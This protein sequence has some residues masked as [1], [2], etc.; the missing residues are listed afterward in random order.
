MAPPP[1]ALERPDPIEGHGDL[2]RERLALLLLLGC[3]PVD[4]DDDGDPDGE[5]AQEE[6][7]P[8]TAQSERLRQRIPSPRIRRDS[9]R[10]RT[11]RRNRV[12][13]SASVMLSRDGRRPRGPSAISSSRPAS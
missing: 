10:S 12:R 2:G 1:L 3:R 9:G 6:K 13:R 7:K 4:E 5:K 11:P 8:P